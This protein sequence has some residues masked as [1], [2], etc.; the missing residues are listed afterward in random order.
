MPATEFLGDAG[1]ALRQRVIG[2]PTKTSAER[3]FGRALCVDRIQDIGSQPRSGHNLPFVVACPERPAPALP[4]PGKSDV[5]GR[6][7]LTR[8][9]DERGVGVEVRQGDWLLGP[10]AMAPPGALGRTVANGPAGCSGLTLGIISI[11][12]FAAPISVARH[13]GGSVGGSFLADRH[14]R[15]NGSAD[16]ALTAGDAV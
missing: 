6:C 11:G 5:R 7:R 14:L 9:H 12:G 15:S 8:W 13:R 2:T 3:P 4:L 16:D 1:S 10:A